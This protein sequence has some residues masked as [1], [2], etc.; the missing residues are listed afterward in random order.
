MELLLKLAAG[1]FITA[2]IVSVIGFA[3]AMIVDVPI[4]DDDDDEW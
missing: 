3:F 1:I 2:A 4:G